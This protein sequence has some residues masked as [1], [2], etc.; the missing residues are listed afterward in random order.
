MAT[1]HVAGVAALLW[2]AAPSMKFTS[3]TKAY[4]EDH[5][6]TLP[7][8]WF[9]EYTDIHEME[10]ILDLTAD[11]IEPAGDNGVPTE[12]RLGH[13]GL[14]QDFAQGYGQVNVERAV[15]LA[16]TLEEMRKSNPGATVDDAYLNYENILRSGMVQKETNAIQKST[17]RFVEANAREQVSWFGEVIELDEIFYPQVNSLYV[18]EDAQ[19]VIVD[20]NYDSPDVT[21]PQSGL[22]SMEVDKGN[23]GQTIFLVPDITDP[24]HASMTLGVGADGGKDWVFEVHNVLGTRT[25]YRVNFRVVFP[26]A[27]SFVVDQTPYFRFAQ[28]VDSDII[29]GF[30]DDPV[31]RV[32]VLQ[33]YFDL[34]K[35][36][37]PYEPS[38]E[39]FILSVTVQA[40][41]V[42]LS[43]YRSADPTVMVDFAMT[44]GTHEFSLPADELYFV[45]AQKEG[46]WDHTSSDVFLSRD[47]SLSI[48]RLQEKG[49]GI[50][51]IHFSSLGSGSLD[52]V[53]K[54]GVDAGDEEGISSVELQ[55]NNKGIKSW[56]FDD[57]PTQV[58]LDYSWDTR[59][60]DDGDY[61]LKL[62]VY[63]AQGNIA[64]ESRKVTIEN[65]GGSGFNFSLLF[66]LS[67]NFI[68]II[69]IV[70]I[71]TLLRNR[72]PPEA[73]AV[74]ERVDELLAVR[75]E[76][77]RERKEKDLPVEPIPEAMV[78]DAEPEGEK[79][80]S[81]GDAAIP[82]VE[83]D[84]SKT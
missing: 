67:K 84:I 45:R 71:I 37:E 24:S 77:E 2:Q 17:N 83:S 51:Y 64:E 6:D 34:S 43:V 27:G 18:P 55:L 4:V 52:G 62:V 48:P 58:Y 75:E 11:Y 74:E 40:E 56:S 70:V 30:G 22:I 47:R 3:E 39:S 38:P 44:A 72:Q 60:Y 26:E 29:P 1:P 53:V 12:S 63:D 23:G 49:D 61:T 78:P 76:I 42:T 19:Y 59:D 68:I 13:H 14:K 21:N 46:Y 20:L 50:P 81:E 25:E 8:E 10:L 73:E 33:N 80:A 35:I 69:L 28:E 31:S 32:T 15:A 65:D 54:I 41:P 79:V 5:T 16:L 9:E 66:L 7:A 57:K 82:D 36:D